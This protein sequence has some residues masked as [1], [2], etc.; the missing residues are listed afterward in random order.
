MNSNNARSVL[1]KLG[2]V[3]RHVSISKSVNMTIDQETYEIS[4]DKVKQVARDSK[5]E[6][7]RAFYV[8]VDGKRFPPTQLI[9][10]AIGEQRPHSPNSS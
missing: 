5:P 3:V 8:E 6:S 7:M 1:T 9:R 4:A 10:L 2:F